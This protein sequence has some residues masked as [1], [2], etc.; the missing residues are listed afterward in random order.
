ML[1]K[2][3]ANNEGKGKRVSRNAFMISIRGHRTC[4]HIDP[5]YLARDL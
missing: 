4:L 5:I 2:Y 1:E 3:S